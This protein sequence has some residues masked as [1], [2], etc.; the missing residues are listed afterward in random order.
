VPAQFLAE[1]FDLFGCGRVL[2][3]A[4]SKFRKKRSFSIQCATQP[5]NRVCIS[6]PITVS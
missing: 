1:V 5:R 6:R 3:H 4:A 2:G